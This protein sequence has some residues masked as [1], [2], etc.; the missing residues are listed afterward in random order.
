VFVEDV[1]E[2]RIG[3][4]DANLTMS[5][6][7]KMI[8]SKFREELIS[9]DQMPSEQVAQ[10]EI[11][12]YRQEAKMMKAAQQAAR[13]LLEFEMLFLKLQKVFSPP[14]KRTTRGTIISIK[15]VT[16]KALLRCQLVDVTL[17]TTLSVGKWI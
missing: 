8:E 13:Q 14:Y 5:E 1:Y 15:V 12:C 9:L 10:L 11:S 2:T 17:C 3:P 16:Q 4:N 6:M 7:M